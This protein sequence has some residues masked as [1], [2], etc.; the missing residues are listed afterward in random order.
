MGIGMQRI[1][2]AQIVSISRIR[3]INE[4]ELCKRMY[5]VYNSPPIITKLREFIGLAIE[6]ICGLAT[7]HGGRAELLWVNAIKAAGKNLA[8]WRH[9]GTGSLNN[10]NS[11]VSVL[12]Q[13]SQWTAADCSDLIRLFGG[14]IEDPALQSHGLVDKG[15]DEFRDQQRFGP[16]FLTK[17]PAKQRARERGAYYPEGSKE[18]RIPHITKAHHS[19]LDFKRQKGF[20]G[21][22][23][24]TL[25]DCSTVK[26]IDST[27]GLAE[28]C[29]ISGTTADSIFFM[30]HVQDF[31]RGLS[32]SIPADLMPVVQLLP[33]ATMA[34]QGHHTVLECALTLT[35]NRIIQYR[36]GFYGTLRPMNG[37]LPAALAGM[38]DA[39]E[40]D[41][42]NK[43]ILCYW[44]GNE[45]KGILYDR[46]DEI[47]QLRQACLAHG[48]FRWQFHMLPLKPTVAQLFSLPSLSML[49]H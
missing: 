18:T 1:D 15:V 30:K 42:R 45:L 46:S 21:I 14:I 19:V 16:G 29:D 49:P 11:L 31:I 28:G 22:E 34:S 25:M 9:S 17:G 32:E 33:M 38:F 10:V 27:F 47:D 2:R 41:V 39:A 36:I 6:Q 24:T 8:V 5:R 3:A 43:H 35:L 12:R 13:S 4:T 26:K 48:A 20:S 37:A 7:A 44:E 23:K 40:Q